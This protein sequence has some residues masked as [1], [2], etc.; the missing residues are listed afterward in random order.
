M[1]YCVNV[2]LPGGTIARVRM[3]GRPPKACEVCQKRYHTKLCDALVG[4]RTCDV[5]L[6]DTCTTASGKNDFCPKHKHLA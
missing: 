6:C 1:A 2:E 3:S 5:K 4:R